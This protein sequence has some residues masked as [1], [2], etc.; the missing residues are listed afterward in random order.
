[1]KPTPKLLGRLRSKKGI[2]ALS[3]T[4]LLVS[5]IVDPS[6]VASIIT[7]VQSLF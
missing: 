7:F 5:G 3:A 4:A 1:M 2:A 6:G